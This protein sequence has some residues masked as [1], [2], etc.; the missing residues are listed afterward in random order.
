MSISAKSKRNLIIVVILVFAALLLL[1][2][3]VGWIQIVKGQEYSARA[4]QQQTKDQTLK[5]ERGVIYDA[6]GEELA[7]SITCYSIWVRPDNVKVGKTGAEIGENM[8][9]TT[10]IIAANTDVPKPKI[11]RILNSQEKLV[12]VAR[13]L[14]KEADDRIRE[15]DAKGIEIVEDTKRSYPLGESAAHVVGSVNIDNQGLSGLE[16]QYNTFLSGISGRW[17]GRCSG[18]CFGRG[19]C[20]PG[21]SGSP[22]GGGSCLP[23]WSIGGLRPMGGPLGGR[24]VH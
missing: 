8:A 12:C 22:K 18:R 14:D 10:E 24:L 23:I 5:A 7:V 19:P 15:S 13:G 20:S 17:S 4:V 1:I 3:R 11:N 6:N 2:F 21:P 9:A 16:L